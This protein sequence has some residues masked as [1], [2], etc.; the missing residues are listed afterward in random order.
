MRR[1]AKLPGAT[2]RRD[3]RFAPTPEEWEALGALTPP[4]RLLEGDRD[5]LSDLVG[6]YLDLAEAESAAPTRKAAV[7]RLANIRRAA[8]QLQEALGYGETEETFDAASQLETL[9]D[10]KLEHLAARR[11]AEPVT[12]RDVWSLTITVLEAGDLAAVDLAALEPERGVSLAQTV[13]YRGLVEFYEDHR[14]PVSFVNDG[15]P[16]DKQP[17][18][19]RL[20]DAL[21]RLLPDHRA[22]AGYR[23]LASL[24]MQMAR[25]RAA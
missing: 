21:L 6:R 15:A 17:S 13:L 20:T 18:I 7:R 24:G 19:V 22:G 25:A 4:A 23:Q 10:E 12:V 5:T 9:L 2:I 11:G 1:E 16:D 8:K 14:W 3:L